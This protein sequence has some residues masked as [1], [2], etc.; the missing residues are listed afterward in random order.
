MEVSS[1]LPDKL[2]VYHQA[3]VE[4]GGT[5]HTDIDR[6]LIVAKWNTCRLGRV[7]KPNR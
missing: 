1:Q 4:K 7:C 2:P 5:I 3:T 6:Q